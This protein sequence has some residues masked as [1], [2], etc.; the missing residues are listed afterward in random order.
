MNVLNFYVGLYGLLYNRPSIHYRVLSPLRFVVRKL[1]NRQIPAYL[2]KQ[3]NENKG[4]IIEG[5]IVSF[6]SF[7]ER[8]DKVWQ[9]VE[10][11][12]RQTYLPEKI[13]LWLSKDQFPTKNSIPTSLMNQIDGL[14]EIRVMDGDLK[15]YKKCCYAF[16]EYSDKTIITVDDDIFY[17]PDT[18]KYLVDGGRLYPGCIIANITSRLTFCN[19]EIRPY[20]Q[21]CSEVK[22]YEFDNLVQIGAGGVLYPPCLLPLLT[23]RD[24]LFMKLAPQAD[25]LWLNAMA[26]IENIP[27]VKSSSQILFLG[28]EDNAKPLYSTNV[29]QG[30][31]DEQLANIRG[32][33]KQEYQKDVYCE[34]WH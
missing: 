34:E 8:I 26:R 28:I 30:K 22:P 2:S 19:G 14:F 15:S 4:A 1:A 6:T 9:V 3:P 12:K 7:P 13:I 33:L 10:C 23:M 17:H 5:L 16:S 18:I 21:W 11:L 24:D 25:D 29:T 32:Y 27:V 20:R 31:N